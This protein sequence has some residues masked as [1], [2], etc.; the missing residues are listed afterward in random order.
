MDMYRDGERLFVHPVHRVAAWYASLHLRQQYTR[1]PCTRALVY[2]VEIATPWPSPW[3]SRTRPPRCVLHV[4]IHM[5]RLHARMLKSEETSIPQVAEYNHKCYKC[6][7]L[8]R[9][10]KLQAIC[11]NCRI[12]IFISKNRKFYSLSLSSHSGKKLLVRALIK[13]RGRSVVNWIDNQS[14]DIHFY[15]IT[16]FT[17]RR[18]MYI[19]I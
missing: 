19:H 8:S 14:L 15:T 6:D 3:Y 16:L 11:K 17:L 4:L 12:F 9:D 18:Y 5:S 10:G 2:L 13:L 7:T 1:S